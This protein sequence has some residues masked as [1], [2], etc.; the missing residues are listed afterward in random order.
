MEW[1]QK[2]REKDGGLLWLL[3]NDSLLATTYS[4]LGSESQLKYYLDQLGLL[5]CQ[6]REGFG[7]V[8]FVKWCSPLW[9]APHPRLDPE[10]MCFILLVSCLGMF[11]WVTAYIPALTFPKITDSNLEL[12]VKI[13]PFLPSMFLLPKVFSLGNRNEG[14]Q[15]RLGEKLVWPAKGKKL[16]CYT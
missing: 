1:T 5:A 7:V 8:F 12:S 14:G 6:S 3:L 13:N 9:A 10:P 11:I 4:Y 16:M 2:N 15:G